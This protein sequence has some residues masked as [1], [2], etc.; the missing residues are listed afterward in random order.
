MKE[1]KLTIQIK[2]PVSEVFDFTITPSN[3]SLWIDS[4]LGEEIEGKTILVGT[5]Y[6]NKDQEGNL[7]F[8]DVSQFKSDAIFELKSI[9]GGYSVRYTYT[10][11]SNT[12]TELEYFEWVE[13]G[14]LANPFEQKNLEKLKFI[15]ENRNR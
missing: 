1:N 12:E 5:R 11:I 10:T 4:I 3:T 14:D 9:A 7:H 15:L 13:D 8:Y 2:R 6:K